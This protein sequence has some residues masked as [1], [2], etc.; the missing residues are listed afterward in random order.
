MFILLPHTHIQRKDPISQTHSS[1][2]TVTKHTLLLNYS[3]TKTKPS[4]QNV[5]VE[6]KHEGKANNNKKKK[7]EIK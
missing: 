6:G 7:L 1:T 3:A 2:D 5:T 4:L